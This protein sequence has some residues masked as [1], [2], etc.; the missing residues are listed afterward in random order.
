MKKETKAIM[1]LCTIIGIAIMSHLT[2]PETV[3]KKKETFT[4]VKVEDWS[5]TAKGWQL[6]YLN[7]L[8][9]TK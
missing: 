1:L 3:V 6:G 4:F 9:N 8:Y 5:K 2:H 7:H